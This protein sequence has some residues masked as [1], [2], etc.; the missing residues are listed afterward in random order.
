MKVTAQM[1]RDNGGACEYQVKIFE[2][3]WPDGTRITKKACLRAV[4]LGLD[5][6]WYAGAF[7]NNKQREAYDKVID[8]AWKAYDKVIDA[9]WEAEV[10][11]KAIGFALEVYAPT[12]EARNRAVAIALW[13][14]SKVK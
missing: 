6:T 14:A 3:E 2:K 1:L 4:E 11:N 7:F 5:T 10:C 9:A 8:S 12:L 13:Q